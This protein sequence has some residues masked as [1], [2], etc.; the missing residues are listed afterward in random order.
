[1][2]VKV[3]HGFYRIASIAD[4]LIDAETGK[5][6]AFI[7]P[8]FQTVLPMDVIEWKNSIVVSDVSH[9]MHISEI[10]R[11][12]EIFNKNIPVFGNKV[13]AES[14]QNL[15]R[16]FDI[17][18]N[19]AAFEIHQLLVAKTFL[20]FKY[21]QRAISRDSIIKIT[22]N[23]ILVKDILQKAKAKLYSRFEPAMD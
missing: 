17:V 14:G 16:V 12:N 21:Q 2:P 11:V 8:K 13:A 10:F 23:K 6:A 20:F 7:L 18:F 3:A 15:G 1:M 9:V 4:I 22:K 5:I 19:T